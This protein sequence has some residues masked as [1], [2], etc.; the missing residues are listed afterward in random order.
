MNYEQYEQYS[1]TFYL[2]SLHENYEPYEQYEQNSE[3]FYLISLHEKVSENGS[4]SSYS[5]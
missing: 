1:K 5:S 3:T 4:Y 2:I